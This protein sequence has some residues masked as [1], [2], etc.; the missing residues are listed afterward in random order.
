MIEQWTHLLWMF[1][2]TTLLKKLKI[3][4]CKF[5]IKCNYSKLNCRHFLVFFEKA[6]DVSKLKYIRKTFGYLIW[7]CLFCATMISIGCCIEK[8]KNEPVGI[9]TYVQSIQ[10]TNML[11]SLRVAIGKLTKQKFCHTFKKLYHYGFV[12]HVGIIIQ[13]PKWVYVTYICVICVMLNF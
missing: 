10:N 2:V 9:T 11:E 3:F 1:W 12:S 4:Y 5:L 8:Y 7:S 6:T 13:V